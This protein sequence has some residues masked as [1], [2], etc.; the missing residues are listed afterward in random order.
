GACRHVR[1]CHRN[2]Q[3]SRSQLPF[4]R[5]RSSKCP[6][7]ASFFETLHV[8]PNGEHGQVPGLFWPVAHGRRDGIYQIAQREPCLISPKVFQND[9]VE[10]LDR[11]PRLRPASGGGSFSN[12]TPCS[13]RIK[14]YRASKRARGSSTK[15]RSPS[16]QARNVPGEDCLMASFPPWWSRSAWVVTAKVS[17]LGWSFSR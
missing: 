3:T 11:L 10:E 7:V 9:P 12:P 5:L 6:D 2:L 17:R 4:H 8:P 15:A 16:P 1:V 13:A 14:L